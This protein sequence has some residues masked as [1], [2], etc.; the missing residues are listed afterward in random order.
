MFGCIEDFGMRRR[1]LSGGVLLE[2]CYMGN[3]QYNLGIDVMEVKE[4]F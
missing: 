1:R 4:T 2:V 3:G